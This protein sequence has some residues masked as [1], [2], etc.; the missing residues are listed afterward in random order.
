MEVQSESHYS[1]SDVETTKK[2]RRADYHQLSTLH[3]I[4]TLN[5]ID[6]VHPIHALNMAGHPPC[7][8]AR[9]PD[10]SQGPRMNKM[11]S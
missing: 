4:G 7:L 5:L 11:E 2:I 8:R 1:K 6:D 10:A 3:K 9:S